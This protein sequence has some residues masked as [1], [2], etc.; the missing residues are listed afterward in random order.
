MGKLYEFKEEDAYSFARHVH[1]EAK[2]RGRE[3]QFYHCPYC[4]GGKGGKD[5]GLFPSI[6]TPGSSNVYVPVA[7]FPVI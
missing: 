4:R 5:K 7:A 1:I 2:Q 6:C 3:L